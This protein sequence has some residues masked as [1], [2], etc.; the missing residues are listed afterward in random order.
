MIS[1]RIKLPDIN[2]DALTPL[3]VPI[4]KDSQFNDET[5]V[6]FNLDFNIVKNRD[7]TIAVN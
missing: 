7:Q 5:V 1:E 3:T 2:P 4:F 6:L